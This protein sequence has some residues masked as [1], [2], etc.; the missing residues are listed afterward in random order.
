ME[1]YRH[2]RSVMVDYVSGV[3]LG[4][5]T[6]ILEVNAEVKSDQGVARVIKIVC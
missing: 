2:D 5:V 6:D 1:T 4:S 3:F